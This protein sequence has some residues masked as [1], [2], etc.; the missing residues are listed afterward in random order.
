M[1]KYIGCDLGGTNIK[2]AIVDSEKGIVYGVRSIPTMAHKGHDA[3]IDRIAEFFKAMITDSGIDPKEILGAGV[4][5]PGAIDSRT[6][7]S[8]FMTNLPDHWEI[9]IAHV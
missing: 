8:V 1:G 7:L 9:G 4:G 5:L 2:G 3:V 6:G